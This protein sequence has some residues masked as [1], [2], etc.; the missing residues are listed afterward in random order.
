MILIL[1]ALAFLCCAV[2]RNKFKTCEN[3]GFCRRN[4]AP[5]SLGSG[6]APALWQAQSARI[7]DRSR[8]EINLEPT[9]DGAAKLFSDTPTLKLT[10]TAF[11]TG[12][13]RIEGDEVNARRARYR[14]RDVLLEGTWKT[15]APFAWHR[16]SADGNEFTLGAPVSS[17]HAG[18]HNK[19]ASSLFVSLRPLVIAL[20]VDGERTAI[21]NARSLF[22]MEHMRERPPRFEPVPEPPAAPAADAVESEHEYALET[23]LEPETYE[24]EEA[25]PAAPSPG[26]I[27]DPDEAVEHEERV[28][29]EGDNKRDGLDHVAPPAQPPTPDTA[30]SVGDRDAWWEE[31]FDNKR[32]TKRNGPNAISIDVEFH[33]AEHVYGLP[34]HASS[35]NLETT[36]GA[37]ADE[38]AQPYR[39]YNLDVFEY[40]LDEQVWL[41]VVWSRDTRDCVRV[42]RWHCTVQ[43][44]L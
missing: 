24:L 41:A 4:R 11:E 38:N 35:Y 32:D 43:C 29:D 8:L 23:Q 28:D 39:L 44:R 9:A 19:N 42:H 21:V 25:M 33:G 34:E 12:A 15:A 1:A 20:L 22:N 2:D 40:E 26:A 18:A 10:I 17:Q 6:M 16:Q 37:G 3:S 14:L 30:A 7:V 31:T 36:R 27:M 5:A 13:F